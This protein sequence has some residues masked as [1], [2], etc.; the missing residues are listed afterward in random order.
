MVSFYN[1]SVFDTSLSSP[2]LKHFWIYQLDVSFYWECYL[3]FFS[4]LLDNVEYHI[5]EVDDV[6]LLDDLFVIQSYNQP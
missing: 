1:L 6:I 4:I 3:Y 5:I 2:D